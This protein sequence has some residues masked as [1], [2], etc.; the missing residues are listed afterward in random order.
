MQITPLAFV[1]NGLPLIAVPPE[2]IENFAPASAVPLIDVL[3]IL[4]APSCCS[5]P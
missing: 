5:P 2:V 3:V 4:I 1:V